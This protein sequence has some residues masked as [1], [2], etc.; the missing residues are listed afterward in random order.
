MKIKSRK[1]SKKRKRV[2]EGCSVL[3]A[4]RGTSL[5]ESSVGN[6]TPWF[7]N[8]VWEPISRNSVSRLLATPGRE[9]RNGV[10]RTAFP[11]GVWERGMAVAFPTLDSVVLLLLLLLLLFP[12][13]IFILLFR[14]FLKSSVGNWVIG[15][16]RVPCVYE[17]ICAARSEERRV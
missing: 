17:S 14:F 7:P 15:W 6:D 8:S 11:N 2:R 9:T 10:S 13:L 12:I 16:F 3:A 5:T 1:K 4:S